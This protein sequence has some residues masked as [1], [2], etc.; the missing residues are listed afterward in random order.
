MGTRPRFRR[1]LLG[2]LAALGALEV[3]YVAAGLYLVRSGQ[4]ERWINKHPEKLRV[5]FD[6]AFSVI[7]GVVHFRGFR[8]VQQGRGS[9]LEGVVDGGWG[10][11]DLLELPARRVHVV[12]LRASGVEFRLRPRP[13]T[14]E[15]AAGPMPDGLPRIEGVPW[16]P[17]P[18]P[19]PGPPKAKRG[20]TVVFT[21]AR[22][23]RVREVWI[24][25]R[26]LRGP[27]TVHASV[28]VGGDKRVS[29]RDVDARFEKA[30]SSLGGQQGSS[31]LTLRLRGR[32]EPFDPKETKGLALLPL[33]H[34]RVEIDGRLPSGA[35][36]LDYY[37][38]NAPWVT[39]SGGE[40]QLSAR[41]EVA[42]GRLKPGGHVELSPT[43]LRARFAGFTAEG[44]ATTRLDVED[45]AGGPQARLAVGFETYGLLRTEDATE[46]VLRGTGLRI[47]AASPATI[48][49]LP[50]SDFTGRIELGRAEI[51]R[52][53]FVN[54]FLPGGA[55]FRVKGGSATAEGAFDVAEGGR[56]CKGS[57]TV[58][59]SEIAFDAAGVETAGT[60]SLSLVV[61]RGDLLALTFG[62]DGTRLDL[63]RFN[64]ASRHAQAGVPDWSGSVAFPEAS[65]DMSDALAVEGRVDLRASDT[66]PLVAFLSARKPLKGWEK[67]LL[68]VEEIRGGGRF[69]LA[70]RTLG[71]EGF[72]V[73]GGKIAVRVNARLTE[74]GAFGRVL[75][76]YGAA[77]VG[78]DLRG[79][80]RDLRVLR[81]EHWFESR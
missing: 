54:D 27:G 10:T 37:L 19:P 17:Y 49:T 22:L 71:V 18:G 14:A 4:V 69:R 68:S 64:F 76:G 51:P 80:E 15:E 26:H 12:G 46:P 40:A 75:A 2:L 23:D 24:G 3:A 60:L 73:K 52:L 62:V 20:W 39:F 29:I 81:P 78:I 28:T 72:E 34:A 31:D 8:I 30:S 38:R 67:K 77:S 6:S 65:L 61:P 55:G 50:P 79:Q 47:T 13:K 35:A 21:G 58:K 70:G 41:L 9:Q 36:A 11:I 5:T 25:P 48:G 16:E 66:R 45:A 1:I 33:V 74:K 59:G 53:T 57:L 43:D 63:E 56:S 32:M 7:P 44:R 42:G